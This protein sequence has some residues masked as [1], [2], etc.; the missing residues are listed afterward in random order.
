MTSHVED[1]IVDLAAGQHGVVTRKQ[2]LDVG[3]TPRM[4]QTRLSGGA[5]LPLHRG[6]YLLGH[7][8][9]KLEPRWAREMAAVL[10]CGPGAVV[11]HR[12]AA[13]LWELV[14]PR[15]P[16][17]R[18]V[19]VMVRS[20]AR[21]RRPGIRT[22]RTRTLVP[23][24]VSQLH[25]IPVT[26][27]DRTLRDLSTVLASRDLNRAAARAERRDLITADQ[28]ATLMARQKGR[29]GAPLLRAAMGAGGGPTLTRS[30]AEERFL[31]LVRS[32]RLPVPE[33]NVVVRGHEVDFL[34][35]TERLAVE[36]DGF[37]FHAS[38]RAFENDRRRDAELAAA[39]VHV[40]RVTWRQIVREPRAT[41][42]LLGQALARTGGANYP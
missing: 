15:G 31:E 41:L 20:L 38:R 9:G 22:R 27:P 26:T 35:R 16:A 5:L 23:N 29:H 32:G 28:L 3:L 6:V 18:E 19:E 36:V 14:L 10:A 2:L 4:V 8:C 12:S 11:S 17:T 42:V 21:R 7:L 30:E 25:G 34:W 1:R 39:G 13:R 33:V 37:G 24:E 40:I